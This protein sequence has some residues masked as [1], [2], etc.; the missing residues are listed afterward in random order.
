ML[1]TVKSKDRLFDSFS[2][3][4]YAFWPF[5]GQIE[6]VMV[7]LVEIEK[8]GLMMGGAGSPT[9]SGTFLRA[10]HLRVEAA[11][12]SEATHQLQKWPILRQRGG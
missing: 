11:G 12:A 8:R 5:F 1:G 10:R 6:R 7:E 3:L 2:W 4:F 9:I